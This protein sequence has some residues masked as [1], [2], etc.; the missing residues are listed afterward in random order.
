MSDMIFSVALVVAGVYFAWKLLVWLCQNSKIMRVI[1][2]IAILGGV[3]YFLMNVC[4]LSWKGV[5]GIFL[6]L[7]VIGL[8]QD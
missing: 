2:K 7:L 4:G 8:A 3:I 5:V 6:L 1:L